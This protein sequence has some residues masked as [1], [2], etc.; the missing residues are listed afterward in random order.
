MTNEFCLKWCGAEVS[1][2][3]VKKI[4][5]CVC[6]IVF[7]IFLPVMIGTSIHR[8]DDGE[9]AVIYSSITKEIE[10]VRGPGLHFIQPGIEGEEY[11]RRVVVHSVENAPCT[12][13]DGIQVK[14]S[15][16]AQ[17]TYSS[18]EAALMHL[19][20]H[21]GTHENVDTLVDSITRHTILT[22]CGNLSAIDMYV[23]RA[24]AELRTNLNIRAAINNDPTA[25]TGDNGPVRGI[26][27]PKQL[28]TAL[29]EKDLASDRVEV[30][31]RERSPTL[32]DATTLFEAAQFKRNTSIQDAEAEAERIVFKA[33]Q[34]ANTVINE[35]KVL[36]E[37]LFQSA[38]ELGITSDQLLS[39]VLETSQRGEEQSRSLQL[40]LADCRMEGHEFSCGLC[41][42]SDSGGQASII[43]QP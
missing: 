28:S 9:R 26:Y 10:G 31:K 29:K 11:S 19:F 12:T 35:L 39:D 34:D 7:M 43:I 4:L 40:C 41:Y 32:I 6:V 15:V 3:G 17:Y 38:K 21:I 2:S 13:N 8:I 18:E 36:G 24:E 20:R 42:L 37:N 5:C 14:M 1:Q 22:T 33:K 23:N 25:I 16:E 30:A 27:L